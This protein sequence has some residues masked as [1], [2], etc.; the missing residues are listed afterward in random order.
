MAT[1]FARASGQINGAIW[2]TS[3]TGTAASVTFDPSDI[4]VSNGFNISINASVT[5][6]EI[7]GDTFGGATAGG[8]WTVGSAG[9]TLTA[10]VN[11]GGFPSNGLI[12]STAN[13]TSFTIIGNLIGGPS[14]PAVRWMTSGSVLNVVGSVTGSPSGGAASNALFM[15]CIGSTLNLTG[16]ITGGSIANAVGC[17]IGTNTANITGIVTGGS[18]SSALGLNAGGALN[19]VIT[20]GVVGAT[21]IGV[22]AAGAGTVTVIGTATGGTVVGLAQSGIGQSFV[23]RARGGPL[24][25]SAAGVSN[26][27][28]GSIVTVEEIE[29]GD[30]GA[31]PTS[32]PIIL[33]DKTSNVALVYRFGLSKKTLIDTAST[34]LMPAVSNVKRGI[35][36][37]AGQSVGTMNVPPAASVEFGVA[38]DNTT[39]T[40]FLDPAQFWDYLSSN[41]TT[42]NSIGERLKNVA[43]IDSVNQQLSNALS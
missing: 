12:Q 21:A 25:T 11:A 9:W 27:T 19:V 39:G 34:S 30:L 31:S 23:T 4:L 26:G 42:P 29:Y 32:G 22:N 7:R 3:P 15:D 43:T 18:V 40:A 16:N 13:A 2:A 38:V 36:Y 37:N 35:S 1:Y 24:A 41:V 17:S 14:A 28:A 6:A 8:I 33:S 20:G 5:V 10:N